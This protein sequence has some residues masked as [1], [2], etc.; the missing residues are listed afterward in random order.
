LPT[1]IRAVPFSSARS[2]ELQLGFAVLAE[3]FRCDFWF[4]CENSHFLVP[5]NVMSNLKF[6]EPQLPT[7]VDQ[8]PE[9]PQWIHEVKH[10]GYRSL[11]LVDRGKTR[12][13]TRNGFDWTDRYPSIVRAASEL[14]CRSAIID[15]EAI[16]QSE[17]GAS[18]FEA[19]RLIMRWQ[20]ERLILYA[21]DLLHIDGR[22][23]RKEPL[24]E[25]R[26]KLRS[27]VAK[28]SVNPLQF[29]E[30]F[31]G[32]GKALF[33][34][35]AK[36]GL[37]GIVSKQMG[38]PY[39]SGRSKAWLKTKCFTESA[40]VVIGTARDRKSGVLR[41]LLAHSDGVGL[42][43]AGAAFIALN[44]QD[45]SRLFAELERLGVSRPPIAR[46]G[47]AGAR[48]CR[49]ELKVRARYLAGS[50]TLRHATVKSLNGSMHLW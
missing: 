44:G 33:K 12:V 42:T 38:S 49:P 16:V 26:A 43:Y 45:R 48:W 1:G 9:G 4:I 3:G 18:D 8:P 39:R 7:L 14:R 2:G 35:C 22:D 6:V 24:I 31:T 23:I 21:F 30:E 5:V 32:S 50:R 41:T 25:R 34:A 17:N 19:L 29:S 20:P 11:L 13:Y 47:V 10:D 46:L 37:E 15:D 27:L 40:F 36:H 28:S